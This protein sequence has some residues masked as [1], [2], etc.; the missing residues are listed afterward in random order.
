MVAPGRRAL[1]SRLRIFR[2]RMP[3]SASRLLLG[4]ALALPV[5]LV[6]TAEPASSATL[7]T[8]SAGVRNPVAFMDTFDNNRL[9]GWKRYDQ[10]KI[11]GPSHWYAAN[12]T[13]AQN[14]GIYGGATTR[15]T[16][17]KPGTVLVAGDPSW[18]N[19]DYAVTASSPDNDAFG[20]VFRY[21]DANNY[22]RF[23]MDSQRHYRRLVRVVNG[24][25][26]KLAETDGG[27][28]HPG[29]RYRIRVLA[30][31]STIEVF[32]NDRQI[33]STPDDAPSTGQ[34][35]LYTWAE[36]STTFDG[37]N[38]QAEYADY[39][40][41]AVVPDTQYESSAT[42][43]IMKAQMSW[44]AA[45]RATERIAMVLQEGDVVDNMKSSLQWSRARS[46]Y[47]YLDGKVPFVVAAGNHDEEVIAAPRP[48]LKHPAAFN[49]FVDSF[50]DYRVAG[51]YVRGD[52]RNTFH[53]LSAGGLDMLILNLD[54]G[55]E[56][57]VLAWADTVAARYPQR[58]IIMLTH[59]Y[60]GTDGQLR[61]TTNLEDKSLPHTHNPAWNDGVQMWDKFVRKHANVQFVLNGHVVQ[62]VA[63]DKPWS[64]ARLVSSN[65]AGRSVYQVLTN[66]QTFN[67]GGEGYLRLFR[68]YPRQGRV[69]VR[70]FSPYRHDS[71]TDDGNEFAFDGVDFGAW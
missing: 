31:D 1:D 30:N 62:K 25:F 32:L 57:D 49:K 29:T 45:N 54:F 37:V 66:Y 41:V 17:G 27:G 64:V 52:Y 14:R 38:V 26:T 43:Q 28:Y 22:Y 59:D 71:L 51:S 65:D 3:M 69:E 2:R 46:Y 6:V 4:I 44:L 33:M 48:H 53:L 9:S 5:L 13:V 40:T 67:G 19:V 24:Q 34:V 18:T 10:G 16:M 35:G 68:I 23:S 55:A 60:L 36:S 11:S 47:G 7:A 12:R 56:D 21:Q 20:V 58:H 8:P 15:S 42:P 61:G 50:L 70:T 63:E 39:F